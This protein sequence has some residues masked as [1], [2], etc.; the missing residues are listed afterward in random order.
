M[1]ESQITALMFKLSDCVDKNAEII[2]GSKR[3]DIRFKIMF[4][5][6]YE[7]ISFKP[8]SG[9][10]SFKLTSKIGKSDFTEHLAKL[11]RFET[12]TTRGDFES[13]T[14]TANTSSGIN[15]INYIISKQVSNSKRITIRS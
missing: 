1:R 13:R 10:F 6:I 8:D 9:I 2:A 7:S 3:V 14:I 11:N 4:G 15:I 12:I 5:N